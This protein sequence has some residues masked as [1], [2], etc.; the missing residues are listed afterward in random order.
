MSVLVSYKTDEGGRTALL[1]DAG[2]KYLRI[3]TMDYPLRVRS[4]PLSEWKYM[5]V[6]PIS[7]KRARKVY[8][9]LAI[10]DYKWWMNVPTAVKGAL[11]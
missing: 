8:K 4:V 1:V 9:R 11:E 6:L 2:R 3:M 7:Y 5:T 10:R